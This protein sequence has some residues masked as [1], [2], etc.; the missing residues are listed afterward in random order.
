MITVDEAIARIS[1][2]ASPLGTETVPTRDA[3]GRVLAA[4]VHSAHPLPLFDQSAVD[5]YAVRHA[6][7][8]SVPATLPMGPIVAAGHQGEHPVLSP[9]S[10]AR[11]FTGGL[12]P[13]GADTIVR[14]ELTSADGSTVT[15]HGAVAAGA[16]L[17]RMGEELEPGARVCEAGVAVSPGLVG[18]L[19]LAGVQV[20]T[21]AR[22]PRIIVLVTGDEIVSAG[23]PLGLGQVPDSNG[24]LIDAV[25]RRWDTAPVGVGHVGDR[26]DEVTRTLGAALD[27]ADLVIT[28]GGVSVG[29]F[30]F[31]PGAAASLGV[32]E[33]L[34]KVAQRPGGPLYVGRRGDTHLFGLPG[35][36]AAVL[37]NLH[38]Y[39]RLALDVMTGLDPRRRWRRGVVAPGLWR[40]TDRTFWMRGAVVVDDEG[41]IRL[42]E[43]DRQASHMLSNLA[44]A[45]ALVRVPPI[46]S[47]S[48]GD[49]GETPSVVSWLPL[50]S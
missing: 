22:R 45:D 36:P 37:V 7:V 20:V 11:I 19:V 26:F 48:P 12:L 38:V 3:L 18:A 42:S 43:L 49:D 23:T 17:R 46:S 2:S 41:T 30:D 1:A 14:Q 13:T 33:V 9:G 25:L 35:N 44:V 50:G 47:A 39:V 5:G 40:R 16:D 34:W 6:D 31:V 27:D 32:E 10:A 29:D 4:P 21:V 28:T 15:V 8:R 24:P